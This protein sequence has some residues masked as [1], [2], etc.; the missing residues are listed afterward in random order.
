MEVGVSTNSLSNYGSFICVIVASVHFGWQLFYHEGVGD[1]EVN[2]T[3]S[4]L[5]LG[6]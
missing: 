6:R 4:L 1:F 2:Y 3:T 5:I